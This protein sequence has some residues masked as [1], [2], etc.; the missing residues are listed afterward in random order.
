MQ[1]TQEMLVRS[2]GLVHPL[3]LEIAILSTVLAWKIPLT[4]KLGR[5]QSMGLQR[6][7]LD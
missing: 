4:E 2:L 5:L 7:G 1:E 6:V 3:E